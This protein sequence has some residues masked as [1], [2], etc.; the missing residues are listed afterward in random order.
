VLFLGLSLAALAPLLFDRV[1]PRW[2]RLAGLAL[3]L[4]TFVNLF[5]IGRQI[6]PILTDDV[7]RAKPAEL[8]KFQNERDPGRFFSAQEDNQYYLY[9]VRDPKFYAIAKSSGAGESSLPDHLFKINGGET[10]K[11][12]AYERFAQLVRTLPANSPQWLRVVNLLN[13]RSFV[14]TSFMPDMLAG[15][16]PTTI[17]V[18]NN[19][20]ALPRAL[21]VNAWTVQPDRQAATDQASDLGF[22]PYRS[23]VVDGV[24]A[25]WPAEQP[26]P[27]GSPRAPIT[28]LAEAGVDKIEYG[29]N[30]VDLTAQSAGGRAL[31]FLDDVYYPGWRATVDGREV[32]ILRAD[33][34]FRAVPL[35]TP[36][37]HRVAFTYWPPQATAGLATTAATLL[38]MAALGAFAWRFRRRKIAC[39]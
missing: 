19:D 22:D 21:V 14:A 4:L 15:T 39:V 29:W 7:Y 8:L 6:H 23:V 35:E 20:Q 11:L 3:P 32:P 25:G 18:S 31:L 12:M 9:G 10:L 34:L 33:G 27:A 28:R 1:S 2:R 5:V 30:R 13:L 24:P 36:G 37:R 26:L 16:A 17:H 38:A